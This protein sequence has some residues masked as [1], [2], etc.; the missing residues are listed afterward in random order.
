[1]RDLTLRFRSYNTG[2]RKN[3][4]SKIRFA[5]T[6]TAVVLLWAQLA[7]TASLCDQAYHF[8][9]LTKESDDIFW[10]L[11]QLGGECSSL[12][13]MQVIVND[14]A[15]IVFQD[16]LEE[17]L[18]GDKMTEHLSLLLKLDNA[19]NR[20]NSESFSTHTDTAEGWFIF[21]EGFSIAA[22][23]TDPMKVDSFM[24]YS[25][26]HVARYWKASVG[27]WGMDL[28]QIKDCAAELLYAN[29]EGLYIDYQIDRAYF[30]PKSKY[31]LIFTRQCLGWDR[32]DTA[33]GFLILR[34]TL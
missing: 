25:I 20:L 15:I 4:K 3:T 21:K 2:S 16:E 17:G 1:M 6:V 18:Y 12:T 30:F 24:S 5:I 23:V 28:P 32:G 29:P 9:T 8:L 10:M 11:L 31:L 34:L 13:I 7:M 19:L 14:T 26:Y 27:D 22:P 33:H